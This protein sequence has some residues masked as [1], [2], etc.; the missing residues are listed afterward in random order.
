MKML[1][2]VAPAWIA[3]RAAGAGQAAPAGPAI[4]PGPFVGTRE[5]LAAYQVPAWLDDAK[6]GIWAH[7]GPQSAPEQGDWYARNMYIQGSRQN[8][9]HVQNYGHPSK[10]GYKDIVSTWTGDKFDPDYLMQLYKKAG[11]K[12][13]VSM[14]VHH[15][16]FD[17]W[18]SKYQ[19]W[20]AAKMGIKR[21]VVGLWRKAAQENGLRSSVD[22][23]QMVRREPYVR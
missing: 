8:L 2:G 11:A 4:T 16:N 1:A 9:Y 21:D 20:N 7:W 5:S 6:F 18:D 15:D 23:L 13:F 22:Q 14:G 17:M 3:A 10:F 12:Y 19:R